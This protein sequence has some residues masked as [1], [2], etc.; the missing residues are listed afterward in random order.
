MAKMNALN[1]LS[2][3]ERVALTSVIPSN[4]GSIT[5]MLAADSIREKT[6]VTDE[7]FRDAGYVQVGNRWRPG[8]EVADVPPRDIELTEAEADLVAVG[9]VVLQ[10][11]GQLPTGRAAV[12]VY[13]R[14]QDRI[15]AKVAEL[16]G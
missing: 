15:D 4:V 1:G 11:R 16:G 3:A 9:F 2:L 10:K 13:R 6:A 14:L 5:E 8:R 7:E 12:S